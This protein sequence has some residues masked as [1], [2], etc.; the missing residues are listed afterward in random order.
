M[1][2]T[3]GARMIACTHADEISEK[4]NDPQHYGFEGEAWHPLICITIH[5]LRD[6]ALGPT[7]LN[8]ILVEGI[9]RTIDLV[10][11]IRNVV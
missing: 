8:W 11:A 4:N 1:G 5:W 6:V 2:H 7:N 3:L 9:R 10:F